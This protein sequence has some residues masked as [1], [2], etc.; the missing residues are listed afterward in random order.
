M[1][2]QMA[3]YS[4]P[5]KEDF[6]TFIQVLQEGNYSIKKYLPPI[7]EQWYE[8]V[9]GCVEYVEHTSHYEELSFSEVCARLLY[10][11]AK[12]HEL[13]DGN[14]RSSVIA[15]YLLCLE[16]DYYISSPAIVKQQAKRAAKTNG[17][18]NVST[19]RKR[20]ALVLEKIM[21]KIPLKK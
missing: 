15:V 7:N 13:G 17:S 21:E 2:S 16:N 20:L 6:H 5:S 9:S 12:R 8:V 10:K 11:V 4:Y 1:N 3:S 14:K 19:L 18:M